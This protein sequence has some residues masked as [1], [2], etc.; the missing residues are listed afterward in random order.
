MSCTYPIVANGYLFVKLPD[1][2]ALQAPLLA[3]C[4]AL[5]VK[6]TILLAQEGINVALAG[7]RHEVE[8]VLAYLQQDV[9][10]SPLILH[11]SASDTVP[12][13][14]MKVR[15]KKEI[16]KLDV[17]DVDPKQQ[18][19]QYV[20]P[21]DWNALIS[22][23]D[24]LT[25]DTRNTYEYALG[26]FR[27]AVSPRT[28][29]F[30]QFPQYVTEHLQDKKQQKIAMY[31]TGGIRCEKS[32]SYL[33]AQGFTQIYHLAGGILQYLAQVPAKDSLWEGQCF[34]F[35]DRIIVSK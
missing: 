27:N 28:S 19:G 5:S 14:R 10:F 31:C 16:V 23:P 8:A 32:T 35:D 33:L 18:V 12:F 1:F 6:G 7:Q 30:S 20:A 3:F 25:I 2:N 29:V 34:V 17:C 4:R 22:A 9:R 11:Y 24:V 21:C 13:T 26:C 15:L